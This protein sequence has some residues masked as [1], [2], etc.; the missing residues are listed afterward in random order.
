MRQGSPGGRASRQQTLLGN[1][2]RWEPVSGERASQLARAGRTPSELGRMRFEG[3]AACGGGAL[4]RATLYFE[5]G[6]QDAL[7]EVTEPET[8][9]YE[10]WMS[11]PLACSLAL[12][13]EKVATL[14]EAS[15]AASLEFRPSDELRALL[16]A[17]E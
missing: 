11:T 8:C 14:E 13:R 3:G 2:T 1:F 15:A 17:P 4:R 12:L 7:L 16:A 10:A 9:V 6:E 5:C